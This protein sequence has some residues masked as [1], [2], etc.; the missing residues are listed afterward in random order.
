MKSPKVILPV[1]WA[2]L[3]VQTQE[4]IEST[5]THVLNS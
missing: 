4:D 2:N 3:S 1:R 5:S